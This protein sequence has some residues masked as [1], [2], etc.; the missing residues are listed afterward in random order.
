MIPLEL[1]IAA[2]N[3]PTMPPEVRAL[4]AQYLEQAIPQSTSFG[5]PDLGGGGPLN[6]EPYKPSTDWTEKY[7]QRRASVSRTND[8]MS[9]G[10]KPAAPK[11]PRSEP[12]MA[13]STPAPKG[14][15]YR[16]AE[17]PSEPKEKKRTVKPTE[18]VS[19]APPA[20]RIQASY[21]SGQVTTPAAR[22]AT[23]VAT[24]D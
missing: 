14:E 21:R 2:A 24:G 16:K 11:A 8:Y 15:S 12:S 7:D 5:G 20:T 9:A 23:P 22:P 18:S 10:G 1:L 17:M 4:A 13:A 3:D 19:I 6:E